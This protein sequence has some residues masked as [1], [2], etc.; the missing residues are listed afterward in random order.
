MRQIA[1]FLRRYT[2]GFEKGYVVQ[3]GVNTGAREARRI[4]GDYQLTVN[5]V[6]QARKFPVVSRA[7]LTP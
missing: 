1:A 7:A 4:L 3:S 2:P 5:D 6:L